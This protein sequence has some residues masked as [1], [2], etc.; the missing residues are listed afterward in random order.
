ML[1]KDT[2]FLEYG[3]GN[4]LQYKLW[5]DGGAI[6]PKQKCKCFKIKHLH[7]QVVVPGGIE[8]PQPEPKSG[9]LPLCKGTI[10]FPLILGLQKYTYFES[11]QNNF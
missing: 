8:P 4:N 3:Q 5:C 6:C 10:I 2:F 7:F 11:L 1:C 9:A